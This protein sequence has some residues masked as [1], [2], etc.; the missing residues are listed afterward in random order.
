MTFTTY[1]VPNKI[2]HGVGAL[3]ALKD[4]EGKQQ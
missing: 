3:E 1:S 2:V 4:L